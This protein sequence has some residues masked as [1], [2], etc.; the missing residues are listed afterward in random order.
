MSHDPREWDADAGVQYRFEMPQ[1]ARHV[2]AE[3]DVDDEPILVVFHDTIV[4]TRPVT[5]LDTTEAQWLAETMP[6]LLAAL[7]VYQHRKDHTR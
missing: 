1:S 3:I 5:Y 4:G 7:D 2:V 6:Q